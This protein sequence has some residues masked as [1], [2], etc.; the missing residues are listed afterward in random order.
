[1][2]AEDPDFIFGCGHSCIFKFPG[3][4]STATNEECHCIE[5]NMSQEEILALRK[6]IRDLVNYASVLRATLNSY[7]AT[8]NL[9][10]EK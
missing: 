9:K 6:K 1:M 7:R 2:P 5:R 3:V 4:G 10:E 8:R